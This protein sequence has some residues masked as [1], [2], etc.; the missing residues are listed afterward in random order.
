MRSSVP[1]ALLAASLLVAADPACAA[2][3]EHYGRSS[4]AAA[5]AAKSPTKSVRA[6][7]TTKSR[8]KA[9]VGSQSTRARVPPANAK[10][11]SGKPPST[12]R[13]SH[14]LTNFVLTAALVALALWVGR[15]G[16]K[17][18][19]QD[20]AAPLSSSAPATHA[21]PADEPQSRFEQA[22]TEAH[23]L[24]HL[25]P[26]APRIDWKKGLE[27]DAVVDDVAEP[28]DDDHLANEGDPDAGYGNAAWQR[29]ALATLRRAVAANPEALVRNI[30]L[31][32]GEFDLCLKVLESW[33]RSRRLRLMAQANMGAFLGTLKGLPDADE[34]YR[35]FNSKRVDFL[36]CDW[37][38][39][40]LIVVEYFGGGHRQGTSDIRDAIKREAL[41]AAR[42]PLIVVPKVYDVQTVEHELDA[43]LTR[44]RSVGPV[45]QIYPRRSGRWP[46][47]NLAA[48]PKAARR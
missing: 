13:R 17:P 33:A 41:Q 27:A 28:D 23:S 29:Q 37:R 4:R 9:R 8:A 10:P 35:A 48:A 25:T 7:T 19:S 32:R 3:P 43:A 46:R 22:R 1:A 14:V 44:A 11:I 38:C 6:K 30:L 42:I 21:I 15:R 5:G 16:R 20:R 18:R 2:K 31:N 12:P 39:R 40:P 47:S 36:V 26:S 45:D 24:P 34:V